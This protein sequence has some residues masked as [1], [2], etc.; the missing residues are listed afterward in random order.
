[1]SVAVFTGS[2]PSMNSRAAIGDP[3]ATAYEI[4]TVRR[5]T[6]W[7]ACRYHRFAIRLTTGAT[8]FRAGQRAR[9]APRGGLPL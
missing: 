8:T 1:M 2:F 6:L 7:E 5:H 9:T 4:F 3:G